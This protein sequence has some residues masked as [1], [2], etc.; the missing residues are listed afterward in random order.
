M[1][2]MILAVLRDLMFTSKINTPAAPGEVL[3]S[4]V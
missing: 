4:Q 1:T 2:R 3:T